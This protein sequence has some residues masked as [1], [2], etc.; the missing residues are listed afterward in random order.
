MKKNSIVEVDCGGEQA[1][2][3]VDRWIYVGEEGVCQRKTDSRAWKGKAMTA[4]FVRAPFYEILKMCD[5][6]HSFT[7]IYQSSYAARQKEK[8]AQQLRKTAMMRTKSDSGARVGLDALFAGVLEIQL[9]SSCACGGG[10]KHQKRHR[11]SSRQLSHMTLPVCGTSLFKKVIFGPRLSASLLYCYDTPLEF[12]GLCSQ[13]R[14][15][16]AE[17]KIRQSYVV[18]VVRGLTEVWELKGEG[19]CW[20]GLGL[21]PSGVAGEEPCRTRPTGWIAPGRVW[22]EKKSKCESLK[23]FIKKKIKFRVIDN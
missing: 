7:I 8:Q 11:Y 4:S 17:K 19:P 23:G 18:V 6:N 3:M 21:W 5:K 13:S 22:G 2:S 12:W 14:W 10:H 15:H 1:N 20:K 16:R 9:A